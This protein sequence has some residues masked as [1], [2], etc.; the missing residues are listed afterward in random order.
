MK[1]KVKI[2][3]GCIGCGLCQA[4]A[5]KIFKV[6]D[7]SQIKEEVDCEK[8]KNEIKEAAESCPVK[9]IMYESEDA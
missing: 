2:M 7:V 4:L 5:P 8:Y 9:I 3:P 1:K 6:T